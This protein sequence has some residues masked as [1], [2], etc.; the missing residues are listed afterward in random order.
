[1]TEAALLEHF[2]RVADGSPLPVLLYSVPQF[3]GLALEAPL[4]AQLAQHRNIF[5]IKDSSGNVE[6]VGEILRL[7]P[8]DFSVLVGSATT[9]YPSLCLGAR[10]GVLAVACALPELCVALFQVAC[11]GDHMRARALQQALMEPTGA[12]TA[13]HG[14][15]GL[16]FAM[17]L[18]G[19]AGGLPRRPLRPLEPAAQEELTRIFQHLPSDM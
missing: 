4:V 8:A 5:G 17:E 11:Q 19:F 18:K 16:K 15:A 13:R 12:V 7:V 14:I 9:L 6:R 2:Q 1:M 10:G 3:T